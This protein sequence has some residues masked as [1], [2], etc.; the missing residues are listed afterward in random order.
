MQA[1]VY[2]HYMPLNRDKVAFIPAPIDVD[3]FNYNGPKEEIYLAVGENLWH[4][5]ADL[6]KEEFKD[7]NIVFLGGAHKVPYED[8]HKWY[9]RARYFVHKPRWIDPCPRTVGEALCAGCEL[10]LNDRVGWHSYSWWGD[11]EASIREM[12]N[13]PKKFWNLVSKYYES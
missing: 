5:G 9:H 8:I 10:I 1:E 3:R 11:K 6:I 2:F 12:R 13:S 7:R 4:K